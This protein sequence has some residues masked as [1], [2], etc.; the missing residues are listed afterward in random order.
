[1]LA[2]PMRRPE[3]SATSKSIKMWKKCVT[4]RWSG[5][6]GVDGFSCDFSQ[7]SDR[8]DVAQTSKSAVSQ[9]S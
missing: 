9:V 5:Q 4:L 6:T 7:L 8:P 2:N 1:M 3:E